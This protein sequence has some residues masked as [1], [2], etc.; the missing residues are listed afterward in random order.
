MLK[1]LPRFSFSFSGVR[2]ARSNLDYSEGYISSNKRCRKVTWCYLRRSLPMNYRY[3]VN[4]KINRY[5]FVAS[6]PPIDK[7]APPSEPK[8]ACKN[9]T[10]GSG[11]EPNRTGPGR[12][13]WPPP[14][15]VP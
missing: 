6:K 7:G 3:S 14:H 10:R 2:S 8:G 15:D 9:K 12:V 4:I 11:F 5:V 1:N 13:L